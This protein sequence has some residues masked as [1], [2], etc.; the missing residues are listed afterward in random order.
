MKI[1]ALRHVIR[2]SA[3]VTGYKKFLILGSQAILG[4][5]LDKDYD[6]S[7]HESMELDIAP[8]PENEI[9]SDLISGTIGELSPF[10]QT[11]GYYADGCDMGTAIFP[12]GW[13]QR[14]SHYIFEEDINVYFPSAEDL[15]LS[16]YCAG[17]GKDTEFI[18]KLWDEDLLDVNTMQKLLSQLP[19]E[20]LGAKLGYVKNRVTCDIEAYM[21]R[22]KNLGQER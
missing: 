17:R 2:A 22:G 8:I 18:K 19:A 20:K 11:F 14:V 9:I 15:A 12:L 13:D 1:E 3:G 7:F 5:C 10:H 21:K 4:H 16:K 6:F